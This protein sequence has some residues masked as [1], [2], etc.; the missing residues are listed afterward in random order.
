MGCTGWDGA[1]ETEGEDD[2]EFGSRGWAKRETKGGK[3]GQKR[4][5]RVTKGRERRGRV[6]AGDVGLD[7]PEW[8]KDSVGSGVWVG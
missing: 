2:R 3:R 6:I 8:W 7:R 1:G 4:A 5:E